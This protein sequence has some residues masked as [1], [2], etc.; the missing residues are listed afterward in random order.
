M[1]Y[2]QPINTRNPTLMIFLLDQSGS[3]AEPWGIDATRTKAQGVAE[4]VNGLIN[5]L[6]SECCRGT[7][8]RDR[9]FLGVVGYGREL[10]LG[11]PGSLAGEISRPVS[12]IASCP[13]RMEQRRRLVADGTGGQIEQVSEFAVWIDPVADGQTP[14][15]QVLRVAYQ[16]TADF[17]SQHPDCFP[18]IV[19]NITDGAANDG[20]P[21]PGAASLRGIASSDGNVLLF[22]LHISKRCSTPILY[23]A[24]EVGLPDD[25]ARRLFSMTSQLTPGMIGRAKTKEVP[26]ADAEGARGFAF[27][28]DMAS[29]TTLLDI[30][31]VSST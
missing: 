2:E 5:V 16:V 4:A 23:P 29:V 17:V 15:C 8:V 31:T 28:A 25:N 18:P 6:V 22:N 7:V 24:S 10:N 11:F 1:P 19:F 3:M 30:A 12:Q 26:F 13:L 27:N 21:S 9:Y 14:M 20:D